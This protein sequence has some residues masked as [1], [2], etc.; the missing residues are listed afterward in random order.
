MFRLTLFAFFV[1]LACAGVASYDVLDDASERAKHI[2]APFDS[3]TPEVSEAPTVVADHDAAL[4]APPVTKEGARVAGVAAL[5]AAFLFA[6][7]KLLKS[8]LMGAVWGR[9]PPF[10]KVL[11]V[12]AVAAVAMGADM[13]A[14][15]A[16]W[17]EAVLA[18]VGGLVT[19]LSPSAMAK[20]G[21]A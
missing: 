20:D 4:E 15:G 7:L 11:V 14:G 16:G 13:L 3:S 9:M 1:M 10:V 19:A 2:A 17:V 6:L 12:A 18:V 5:V 8:P 21:A